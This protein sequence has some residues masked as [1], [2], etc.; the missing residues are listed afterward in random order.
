MRKNLGTKPFFYPLSVLIIGSYDEKG[1]PDL[2]NAAWGGLYE[3]D[4]VIL[5]LSQS[6][7]TTENIKVKKAFTI[8]FADKAHL[9][10]ADYVGLVS[11]KNEPKKVEKSGFHVVKS[12]FV[13]APLVIDL[14]VALECTLIKVNEDGSLIGKIENVSID[15]SALDV[16]G[17]LDMTRFAPLSFEP[18]HRTYHVLGEKV[19][20]A[21]K[22][23]GEL[24]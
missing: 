15:E 8:S 5:S 10:S 16:E 21:F 3:A 12:E 1:K 13:D 18:F 22:D 4:K 19:G 11:A 2:M 23:G 6:H 7:Q 9:V 14:P 17:N 24:K 20:T